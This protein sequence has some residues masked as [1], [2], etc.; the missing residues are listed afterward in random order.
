VER[1]EVFSRWWDFDFEQEW[2]FHR[3]G[4]NTWEWEWEEVGMNVDGVVFVFAVR[5]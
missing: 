4:N 3:N 2:E 1:Y 5:V